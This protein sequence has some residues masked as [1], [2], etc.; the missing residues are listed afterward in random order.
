MARAAAAQ[1]EL[2]KVLVIPAGNPPHRTAA[3]SFAD[4][5]RMVQIACGHDALFEPS[6]IEDCVG[7]SFTVDTIER[8]RAEYGAE[9]AW[10]FIIGADAFGE[11]ESWRRWR[12]LVQLVTFAI[13]GR[14]GAEYRIPANVCARRVEGVAMPVSASEIRAKLAEGQEKLDLPA[15]VLNYIRER[16]L[17]GVS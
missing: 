10:Y 17:Y 6:Q 4:R 1:C 8:L 5:F 3:A 14:P 12:D 7:K 16:K 11:I 15:G 13:V 9:V 2:S